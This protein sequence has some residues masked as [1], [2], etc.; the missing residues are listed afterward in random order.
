MNH[1][2]IAFRRLLVTLLAVIMSGV[3]VTGIAVLLIRAARAE[4]LE[5][6][7][8][9]E[10]RDLE[11]ACRAFHEDFGFYV[12]DTFGTSNNT[13]IDADGLR[14]KTELSPLLKGCPARSDV[15]LTPDDISGPERTTI[16]LVFFL[17]SQFTIEG[18]H[19]GPYCRFCREQL[20]PHPDRA[21]WR[22]ERYPAKGI[23]TGEPLAVYGGPGARGSKQNPIPWEIRGV[24]DDNPGVDVR[25]YQYLDK[26]GLIRGDESFAFFDFYVYDCH[27]PEGWQV[28]G[29]EPQPPDHN[30]DFV[31]IFCFG[32]DGRGWPIEVGRDYDLEDRDN[33][34]AL[35]CG[36]CKDDI[37]NWTTE[38]V[39]PKENKK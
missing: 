8:R 27:K 24:A 18:K 10:I 34:A 30:K 32:R 31:D 12:P 25:L 21:E 6:A 39:W 9:A 17:G 33:R 35:Y 16:L 1:G 3:A 37:N 4:S 23:A 38:N 14:A 15:L 26:F 36:M 19:Y 22:G 2:S 5:A 7:C 29:P 20:V 13:Y 28:R 11:R